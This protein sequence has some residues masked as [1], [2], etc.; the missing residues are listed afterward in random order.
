MKMLGCEKMQPNLRDF[1]CLMFSIDWRFAIAKPP[2]DLRTCPLLFLLLFLL[3][4]DFN[5]LAKL[6]LLRT[7][8]PYYTL[9]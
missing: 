8:S 5:P 1:L 9:L 4:R 2:Y 7:Y 3:G 6:L